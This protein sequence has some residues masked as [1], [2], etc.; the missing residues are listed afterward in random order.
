MPRQGSRSITPAPPAPK[1]ENSKAEA[2]D[3]QRLPAR[4]AKSPQLPQLSC[5]NNADYYVSVIA[6]LTVS[7][8]ATKA[9]LAN[10]VKALRYE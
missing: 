1:S 3:E 4:K 8:Q 7:F 6:W 5:P 10:P 2:R 9:A